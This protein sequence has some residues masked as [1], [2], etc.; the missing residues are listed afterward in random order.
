MI[1][2]DMLH[3]IKKHIWS[4]DIFSCGSLPWVAMHRLIINFIINFIEQL[5]QSRV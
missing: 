4:S 5:S 2:R 1:V 3:R